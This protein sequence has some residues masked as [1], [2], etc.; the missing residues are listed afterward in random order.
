M[1]GRDFSSTPADQGNLLLHL[2]L[3]T[4][5]K[6]TYRYTSQGKTPTPQS[7]VYSNTHKEKKRSSAKENKR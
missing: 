1:K 3:C 5:Q 4:E 6:G 2:L 7:G